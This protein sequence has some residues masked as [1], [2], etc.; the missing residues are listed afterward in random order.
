MN[1]RVAAQ[2]EELADNKV[3]LKV[4]VPREEMRH[5]VEHA[6]SDLAGS[7]KIPG[8]RPGKVP[9]Q[10]LRA[11]IGEER[12]LTEAVESHIGG[13]FWNAAANTRIRPIAQPQYDYDLPSSD[14][15]AWSFTATVDVQPKPEVADWTNLDLPYAEA[16]IPPE[17]V[18]QEIEVLRE[19]VADLAPVD[20]RPAQTGDV[21]VVDAV[22]EAG[23]AQR[24]L[25]LELGSGRLLEDVERALIG[26]A[27]GDTRA[28]EYTLPDGSSRTTQV[29]VKEVKEKVLPPAD[30]D[31]AR[32]ASEFD[33]YAELREEIESRLREQ[34]E[35]E[36]DAAFRAEAIDRLVEASNATA[37]GPL[38]EAR[39]RELL[40]QLGRSLD[41]RGISADLYLQLTGQTPEQL[42]DGVRAEAAQS[43]ARELVL[44]AAADKL[45]VQIS[46]DE[47][48][49]LIREEAEA[50]GEDPDDVISQLREAGRF[51]TLRADLRLKETLDRIV[52]EVKRIA[53]DLAQARD[54]LWTPD[55]ETAPTETKL[56]TPASKEPA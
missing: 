5:A 17:L 14:D 11:R 34:L 37:S 19:S 23:E 8:F 48:E 2:V 27:P 45:G 42:A 29:T 22:E 6:T 52:S 39:S 7:V 9:P 10:V 38:V 1:G 15:D 35:Y 26:A 55:K 33:S 54:K 3:R 24:D 28:G 31:L 18:D 44:E 47:V 25:V 43:V 32:A 12:L 30:D 41:R 13:W 20:G 21:V 53:P 4:D 36:L 50:A 56:W 16:E 49:E 51:E 46:D 40:N